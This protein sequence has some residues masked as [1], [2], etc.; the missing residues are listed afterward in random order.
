MRDLR[1]DS[2]LF[3]ASVSQPVLILFDFLGSTNFK[4]KIVFNCN[5]R[6]EVIENSGFC[7]PV[8]VEK[9]CC[10]SLPN[11]VVLDFLLN[12]TQKYIKLPCN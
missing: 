4:R 1:A 3:F 7:K 5:M 8:K 10:T 9:R 6:N 12:Y 11:K 2:F